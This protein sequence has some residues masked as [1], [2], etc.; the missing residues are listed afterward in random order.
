MKIDHIKQK[1]ETIKNDFKTKVEK[2][3]N[4]VKNGV[5][6][7]VKWVEEHP[8]ETVALVT[9]AASLVKSGTA[10]YSKHQAKVNL[11]REQELK[12][13]YTYDR[14][15]GTYLRRNRPMTQN[16]IV[17]VERRKANGEQMAL[18]LRDMKLV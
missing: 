2:A 14:S 4:A 6:K 12:E 11:K 17:E 18:I 13:L 15:I 1:A 9:A 5:N 16:E 7:T 10:V 8:Q 3:G